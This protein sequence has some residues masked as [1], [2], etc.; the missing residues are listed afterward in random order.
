MGGRGGGMLGGK[1]C[2]AVTG[3]CFGGVFLPFQCEL[4]KCLLSL[5]M[6]FVFE[7]VCM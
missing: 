4:L 6:S 2:L 7:I 5:C 3:W 1:P